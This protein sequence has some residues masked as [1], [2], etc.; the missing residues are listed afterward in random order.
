MSQS[1]GSLIKQLTADELPLRIAA[2][3]A[4][5]RLG[6]QAAAAAVALAVAAGDATE[7]VREWAVAALDDLEAPDATQCD[8]LADLV[9]APN[10]DTAYWAATLLGRLGVAAAPASAALGFALAEHPDV[11]VRQRAAWALGQ[12]GPP[13]ACAGDA[14]SAALGSGDERLVRLA[15]KALQRIE[16]PTGA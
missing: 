2:A 15:R 3:E 9:G 14:L 10:A 4:L 6:E 13:A 8:R 16:R 1:V 12:I 11:A 5:C 7:E